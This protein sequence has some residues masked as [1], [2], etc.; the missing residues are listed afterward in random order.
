[1]FYKK[2]KANDHRKKNTDTCF[3]ISNFW[4]VFKFS[5]NQQLISA[6]KTRG[7]FVFSRSF[8]QAKK[9]TFHPAELRVLLDSC[10]CKLEE[11]DS[12][13]HPGV[14]CPRKGLDS[15]LWHLH[16]WQHLRAEP[17][18]ANPTLCTAI[19]ALSKCSSEQHSLGYWNC[20][21]YSIVLQI[22]FNLISWAF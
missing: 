6:M 13:S 18:C 4:M 22:L 14:L 2:K 11:I 12:H 20:L 1:M 16:D 3:S 5:S 7:L 8:P 10:L 15:C 21:G 19:L 9:T 17:D